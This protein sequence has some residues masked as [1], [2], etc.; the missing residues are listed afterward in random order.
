M[1]SI[2]SVIARFCAFAPRRSLP[3]DGDD[4]R[5]G[6]NVRAVNERHP[7]LVAGR[8]VLTRAALGTYAAG[9]TRLVDEA[10]VGI[11]DLDDVAGARDGA[12]GPG[13]QVD[14]LAI[15]GGP[16]TRVDGDAPTGSWRGCRGR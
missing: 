7:R 14:E 12:V 2:G 10:G 16:L 9:I 5:F 11:E 8:R 4:A 1:P 15:R 6:L 13:R 3:R